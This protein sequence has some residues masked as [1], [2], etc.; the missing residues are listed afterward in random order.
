MVRRTASARP[1]SPDPEF[2]SR[3]RV[4]LDVAVPRIID[5]VKDLQPRLLVL[6]GSAAAGEA[7]G[8]AMGEMGGAAGESEILPLS[9]LDLGLFVERPSTA[10]RRRELQRFL[11]GALEERIC[12]LRLRHN[13]LDVGIFPLF[14][15]TRM[16]LTLELAEV[17]R[18][19][20][21]LWGDTSCLDPLRFR[22]PRPFEALRLLTNRA[23][24]AFL[25]AGVETP[26]DPVGLAPNAW[27]SQ[28]G[29]EDWVE[30]HRWSKSVLDGG[31]ALFA[32]HGVH[33]VA[34]GRRCEMLAGEEDLLAG[35][36]PAGEI[37]RMLETWTAWRLAP[38]WPPP[39]P[40]RS[41]LAGLGTEVV[42]VVLRAVGR[43]SFE[44][45]Q[46][47]AWRALL[48]NEGGDPRERLRR[49]MWLM[50]TR[51]PQ[52][53]L[54]A[55]IRLAAR[56]VPVGWPGSLGTLAVGLARISAGG[57]GTGAEE[58]RALLAREIPFCRLLPT[59]E[60]NDDW[61]RALA[62]MIQWIRNAGA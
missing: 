13:P 54:L 22:I 28:P 37:R 19:P 17:M 55:A 25:P 10:A 47:G 59:G 48:G 45:G 5:H 1:L 35:V 53:S 33:E 32:A 56:W 12:E 49:W 51:P 2:D 29:R 44:V 57:A 30:A 9:D 27:T 43:D 60:W 39:A 36:D 3:L 23:V 46:A 34:V 61:W 16:P 42:R 41:A 31:K 8:V 38:V 26:L 7:S 6:M 18:Q 52:L 14:F 58:L 11:D 62:R 21:V 24:E 15:V 20:I 4:L 50:G 40:A